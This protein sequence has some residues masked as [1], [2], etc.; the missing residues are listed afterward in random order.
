MADYIIATNDAPPEGLGRL[1]LDVSLRV[2]AEWPRAFVP[3]R[4]KA[5]VF[6]TAFTREAS[7]VSR[8]GFGEGQVVPVPVVPVGP[9]ELPL[10][11]VTMAVNATKRIIEALFAA[12]ETQI[13]ERFP[14]II[15]RAEAPLKNERASFRKDALPL[16]F[17]R[18]Q[19]I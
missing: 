8:N 1:R 3:R 4:F 7:A 14:A 17:V 11:A 13:A 19:R 9:V 10:H 5:I 18:L 12:L 2:C 16:R 6:A 15:E